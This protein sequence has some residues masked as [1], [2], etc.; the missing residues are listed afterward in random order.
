MTQVKFRLTAYTDAAGRYNPDAPR[1]GNEDNM[2]VDA[3]LGVTENGVFFESDKEII[4]SEYGCLLA[5]ADGM[6]GMNAGEVASEIAVNVVKEAFSKNSIPTS[7]LESTAARE[8]YLK[9]VIILA[10]E[11]IK[12]HAKDHPECLGMGSTIVIAWL[13]GDEVSI[14]WLGDSRIYL[15]R[16]PDG[17]E[18]LSKDHSYV[19]E[20]VDEGTISE[21][22][23]FNHPYN[24]VITRSLGDNSKRA[25]ADSESLRL[26]KGDILLL[27][28]DGLSGVLQ[29]SELA[30]IIQAN[31]KSMS[32]CRV[33]LWKEAENA[34]WHDN[35]TAI[36]CEITEG[37][38]YVPVEP[39][40]TISP[41]EKTEELRGTDTL[42]AIVNKSVGEDSQP[43]GEEAVNI[44]QQGESSVGKERIQKFAIATIVILAAVFIGLY[45]G[46]I[47]STDNLQT[48]E[49]I[50]LVLP[51]S[52][53]IQSQGDSLDNITLEKNDT[54]GR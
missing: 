25:N 15:F 33:A 28:S 17:L 42:E 9:Q 2:F 3:D 50:D 39:A 24:N 36:L 21:E 38:D 40:V 48:V 27:N 49:R 6:G 51:D 46:K 4:L 52:I 1:N 41:Y 34:G 43:F 23:A 44:I 47:S 12:R 11:T 26:F 19:Q 31:R 35:V 10:D 13:Y 16:E 30:R 53:N 18:Q 20:L 45:L 8:Q 22:D 5:V 54:A 29:D 37:E 7:S 32:S 14:A